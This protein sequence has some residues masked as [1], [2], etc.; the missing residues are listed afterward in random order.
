M[1]KMGRDSHQ[2][3]FLS[4]PKN[5]FLKNSIKRNF[6][7]KLLQQQFHAITHNRMIGIRETWKKA[8]SV[9]STEEYK[10]FITDFY[11]YQ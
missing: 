2:S 3:P 4:T 8:L 6:M 9:C 7:Q 10:R 5:E 1:F 11:S